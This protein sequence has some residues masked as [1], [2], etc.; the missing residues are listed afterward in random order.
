M[1][2]CHTGLIKISVYDVKKQTNLT[3]QSIYN[4]TVTQDDL[5]HL[6]PASEVEAY[7]S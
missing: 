3:A 5:Y 1:T 7:I 4:S 6:K 2:W